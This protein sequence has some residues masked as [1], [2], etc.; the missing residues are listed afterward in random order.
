MRRI[1][2]CCDPH[3]A[4]TA[5]A[6]IAAV[7][8]SRSQARPK[9]RPELEEAGNKRQQDRGVAHADHM[10][11]APGQ[12][13]RQECRKKEWNRL[14]RG[15]AGDQE[16]PIRLESHII[17]SLPIAAGVYLWA[18]SWPAAA[19]C[20][21]AGVLIDVDHLFDFAMNHDL[22]RIRHFFRIMYAS[23]LKRVYVLLHSYELIALLWLAVLTGWGGACAIGLAVGL[24]QHLIFDQIFN[25]VHGFTYFLTARIRCGFREEA[26]LKFSYWRPKGDPAGRAFGDPNRPGWEEEQELA[27]EAGADLAEQRCR[28]QR[29]EDPEPLPAE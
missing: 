14:H 29:F 20:F 10:G 13:R 9:E 11:P 18:G 6:S 8:S 22:R 21:L 5:Q 7:R 19:A 25:E 3:I 12:V 23:N 4:N 1:Q 17:V 26:L 2:T 16:R 28:A 24:T 27:V 15:G